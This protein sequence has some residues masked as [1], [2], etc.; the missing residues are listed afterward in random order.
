[1]SHGFPEMIYLDAGPDDREAGDWYCMACGNMNFAFRTT[2]NMRKCGAPKV[3]LFA[4][5]CAAE[6]YNLAMVMSHASF[7]FKLAK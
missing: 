4:L 3:G 2:C 1:M 6:Y 7:R 5:V